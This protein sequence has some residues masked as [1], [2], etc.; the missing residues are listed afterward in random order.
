ML[1]NYMVMTILV[2]VIA[3]MIFDWFQRKHHK[4][5]S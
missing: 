1:G 2:I 4:P 3:L 5:H